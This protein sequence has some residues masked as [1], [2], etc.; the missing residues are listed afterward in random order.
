MDWRVPFFS[1]IEE[2]FHNGG[3]PLLMLRCFL[4]GVS[5]WV[6]SGKIEFF[7]RNLNIIPQY[8][9]PSRIHIRPAGPEDTALIFA[10]YEARRAE[11]KI[12]KRLF[13]G[14]RCFVATNDRGDGIHAAWFSTRLARVAELNLTLFLRLGEAYTYDVYTRQDMRLRGIDSSVRSFRV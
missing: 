12:R 11:D 1:R 13:E 3:L 5:P 7:A 6:E 4:K 9:P 14:D 10:T 8:P 2:V